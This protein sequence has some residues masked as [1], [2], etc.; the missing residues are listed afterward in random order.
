MRFLARTAKLGIIAAAWAQM[1]PAALPADAGTAMPAE[2]PPPAPADPA[3]DTV[4]EELRAAWHRP[5]DPQ[6]MP[7]DDLTLPLERHPNGQ[8]QAL[9]KAAHALVPEHGHLRARDVVIEMYD[10][11]GRLE[12]VFV[13]EN[14]IFDRAGEAGYCPGKVR[15][16]RLGLRITG[17]DMV[18]QMREKTARILS[19]AEVRTDRF[20]R[21]TG[22]LL[23]W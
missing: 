8:A 1:L 2:T 9:L 7:V 11:N 19:Q 21:G 15:I 23:K 20:I 5:A 18:W 22:K 4:L 12:G 6:A 13:A 16:E 10:E 3:P 14:C 17:V